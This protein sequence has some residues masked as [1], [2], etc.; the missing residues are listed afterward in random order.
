MNSIETYYAFLSYLMSHKHHT[1]STSIPRGLKVMVNSL[2][3]NVRKR[4]AAYDKICMR[5]NHDF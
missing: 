5:V 3:I 2:N 1:L 4:D